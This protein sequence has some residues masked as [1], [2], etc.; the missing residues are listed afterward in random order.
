MAGNKSI[1]YGAIISYVGIAINIA[2]SFFYTPW[3][4]RKVGVSDYGLYSLIMSFISYFLMD[5]GLHQAIQR[6]I[7][8]YRAEGNVDMVEKMVGITTKVYLA[9]DAVIFLILVILYFFISNIFTGLTPDEIERLKGLYI[10][11]GTFSVLNFMFKPMAGAMM[12]FE[13]FVEEKALELLNK[14]G[15]VLLVCVALYLGADVYALVLING[16]VALFTSVAKYI[17][18]QY[19]SK[20]KI[21]WLYFNKGELK[22]VFSFSVWTFVISL[23]QRMRITIMPTILGILSNSTEISFFAI[24]ITIEGLLFSFSN[25]LNGLFLPMVSR[26]M[27]KE[28]HSEV[29]SLM[30][31]VGRIQ[32]FVI[33]LLF[34]GFVTFGPEFLNL[35]IGEEFASVYFIVLC[36]II[37]NTVLFT[38]SIANNVVY[39]E[40]K[41]KNTATMTIVS[42]ALGLGL[43][44]ILAPSMGAVGC[45]IGTGAGLALNAVWLNVFYNKVLK[46]DVIQFFKSCHLKIMPLIVAYAIVGYFICRSIVIDNWFLLCM[47]IGVY[48]LGYLAIVWFILANKY[49]KDLVLSLIKKKRVSHE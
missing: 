40:N 27:H 17:V 6:F 24:G 16:S 14:I 9:I 30:I 47:L 20:L 10:I 41:I 13:Y 2:I 3:M 34:S 25:A 21:Q 23:A 33:S 37:P 36:F 5:F 11:A 44:C 7:A 45:A 28:N 8:K 26:M 46:I 38:Q 49:E 1:K 42:S 19:K 32:L 43:A 29:N 39:V 18:F 31:K 22:S 35:W 4:I 12:A 15:A 48:T